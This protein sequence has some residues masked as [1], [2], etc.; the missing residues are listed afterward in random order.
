MV[1]TFEI[2]LP[3]KNHHDGNVDHNADSTQNTYYRPDYNSM[4]VTL[5]SNLRH[6]S[7]L[8]FWWVISWCS[9]IICKK[10]HIYQCLETMEIKFSL[11]LEFTAHAAIIDPILVFKISKQAQ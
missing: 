6:I 7:V 11:L 8:S 1:A 10:E 9:I 5:W 3:D 2:T 4:L